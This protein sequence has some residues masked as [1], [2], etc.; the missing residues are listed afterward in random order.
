VGKAHPTPAILDLTDGVFQIS[1]YLN[2]K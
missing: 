2:H 1:G